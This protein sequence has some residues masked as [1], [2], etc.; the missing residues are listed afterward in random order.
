MAKSRRKPV[1]RA[2]PLRR[3]GLAA[4]RRLASAG[5]SIIRLTARRGWHC[6]RGSFIV[7]ALAQPL[8][9]DFDHVPNLRLIDF[10]QGVVAT[11][12]RRLLVPIVNQASAFEIQAQPVQAVKDR[13]KAQQADQS[14]NL[15]DVTVLWLPPKPF[16]SGE[17]ILGRY[18]LSGGVQCVGCAWT[19]N[20]FRSSSPKFFTM[21]SPPGV[22]R[23]I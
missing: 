22:R 13:H 6:R 23:R 3:G 7:L 9:A 1:C 15:V 10:L 4:R 2:I 8:F 18:R 11:T 16:A 5:R 19:A 14:E 12:T 17:E 21:M 20:Y